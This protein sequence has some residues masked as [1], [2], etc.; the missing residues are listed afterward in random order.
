ME[1]G[2]FVSAL[3]DSLELREEDRQ[4]GKALTRLTRQMPIPERLK[5]WFDS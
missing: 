5:R 2:D 4:M 3:K 1:W